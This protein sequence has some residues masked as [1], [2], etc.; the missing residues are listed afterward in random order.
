M[1]NY[2][3]EKGSQTDHNQRSCSQPNFRGS[4]IYC[5]CH[6]GKKRQVFPSDSIKIFEHL[7]GFVIGCDYE[8]LSRSI[9]YIVYGK[10][11]LDH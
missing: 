6:Q 2:F 4:V 11:L 10:R 1:L 8:G 7:F 9:F 5:S 3:F